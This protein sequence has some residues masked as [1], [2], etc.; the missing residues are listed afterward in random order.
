MEIA[1]SRSMVVFDDLQD[2]AISMLVD[3][4]YNVLDE[5]ESERLIFINELSRNVKMLLRKAGL[6]VKAMQGYCA[7]RNSPE[8]VEKLTCYADSSYAI[9]TV[10]TLHVSTGKIEY[11]TARLRKLANWGND[12]AFT[13]NL[14]MSFKGL[15]G[16]YNNLA[17][18]LSHM[19]DTMALLN[20]QDRREKSAAILDA[21]LKLTM[22]ITLH[23]YHCTL[24]RAVVPVLT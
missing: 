17:D 6:L 16:A 4:Q 9:G 15:P 8:C 23:S 5:E 3:V 13:R 22:P 11:A 24:L 18:F 20:R 7:D 2:L 21:N 1:D 12:L 14:P 19:S 10:P